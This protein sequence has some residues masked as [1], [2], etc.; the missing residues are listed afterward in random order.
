MIRLRSLS[1]RLLLYW[2]VGSLLAY[3]TLPVT[4]I[5][6]QTLLHVGEGVRLNLED[7]TT[8]RARDVVIASLRRAPDGSKFIEFTEALRVHMKRNPEFR[9]AVFD[10]RT[11]ALLPGS[12]VEL[13]K[14]FDWLN[15]F[16]YF[17]A[18]FHVASDTNARSR[19]SMRIADTPLGEV[20]VIT[21]GAYF[22]WDDALYQ[23]YN[24][25]TF[26]NFIN[27]L[28][29]CITMSAIA[30][31]VVR[32]GLA[33]LRSLAAYVANVDVNSLKSR[34]PTADLPT[35]T[36]PFIESVNKAFERVEEG[37]ARQ[38]RFTANSA[39]ELRTPI[40][41]LR[42]RVDKMEESPLKHEII[43]DV[44]RIQNIVEQLLLLAQLKERGGSEPQILDLKEIVLAMAVD[45][46]PIAIDNGRDMQF[47][48]P[49]HPVMARGFRWAIESIVT[50]LVE[51]AVRA[52][53]EGGTIDVRVNDGAIIEVIDHGAGVTP[54]D[55]KMIFEPF[56]RKDEGAPGTGLGL[57]IVKELVQQLE[58]A[59]SVHETPGGGA[60]FK[61]TLPNS[62]RE[63]RGTATF[64]LRDA[65]KRKQ[66]QPALVA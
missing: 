8:K 43:R 21:Y 6:P 63:E 48:A 66:V 51:N 28:P 3:F 34:L 52:E 33:P 59:I 64:P 53:P 62:Q 50:N 4:A 58:G 24:F 41:I 37:V 25:F 36:L 22:H 47:D 42:A 54:A 30:L 57:S 56:W 15:R 38:R 55:R 5:I 16:E 40:T 65:S 46:V 14:T 20:K 1:S 11:G 27:Y 17:A 45:Y 10:T 44:L 13:A 9:F 61:V 2:I 39:H 19:G 23:L 49:A 31:V 60:T 32:Q 26:G 7:W 12:S 29:L 35:E 18:G